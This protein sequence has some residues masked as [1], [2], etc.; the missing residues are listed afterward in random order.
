MTKIMKGLEG[1][2]VDTTTISLVDGKA[3]KL[4]YRGYDID[5]LIDLPFGHVASLVVNGTLDSVLE[6]RLLKVAQLSPRETDLLLSLPEE[7]HPMHVLQGM[8]PLLDHP[9]E[10]AD[11]GEA[12]QGLVIAAKV[13]EL[14]ATHL[15][16]KPLIMSE[17]PT[18][19]GRFLEYVRAPEVESARRAFE[20]VQ[21]LQIEHSFNAGTFAAR[22]VASTLAPIENCIAAAFGTLHGVLHGGADQAALEVAD[23]VGTPERAA[24]FVD[25]CLATKT[26][27]MGMGHR[28][29]KV[30]DPRARHIKRF[31]EAL[32]RDTEHERTFRTLVAI[33]ARFTERMAAQGKSLYANLEFYKGVVYRALGLPTR[34][35]TSCFAMARVYGY[36][37]HFIESREDNRIIRPAAH[38]VGPTIGRT[39]GEA[40][41]T[42]VSG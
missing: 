13:P 12:A 32:T 16:R 3:G 36:I 4:S 26:K 19:V 39:V 9:D 37:A 29:Y 30:L 17:T 23:N 18:L 41:T 7:T 1:V 38:Y 20:A 8:A 24:P 10:F 15:A 31:A 6:E 2:V 27:V 11:Y 35:F 34:F 42:P 28:E 14:I 33:E 21:V 25:E 22:S 5:E 40:V